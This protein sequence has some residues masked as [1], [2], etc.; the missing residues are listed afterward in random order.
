MRDFCEVMSF[1]IAAPVTMIIIREGK[2][3]SIQTFFNQWSS[4]E[5]RHH[6]RS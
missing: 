2:E 6:P 3:R 1:K 4:E 5:D